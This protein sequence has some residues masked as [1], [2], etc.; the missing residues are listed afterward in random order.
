MT[1]QMLPGVKARLI[2]NLEEMMEGFDQE[3]TFLPRDDYTDEEF[4]Q[5]RHKSAG[6]PI[7]TTLLEFGLGIDLTS[8]LLEHSNLSL[9]NRLSWEYNLIVHELISLRKDYYGGHKSNL[10]YRWAGSD[11]SRLQEAVNRSHKWASE[12]EEEFVTERRRILGS[13]L[14]QRLDICSYVSEL[15]NVMAGFTRWEFVVPRYHGD[16]YIWNGATSGNVI[17]SPERTIFLAQDAQETSA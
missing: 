12:L 6:G 10:V 15:G 7:T 2:S 14:G 13:S 8:D 9:L 11:L 4:L 3:A 16:G 5:M 1:L 17:L